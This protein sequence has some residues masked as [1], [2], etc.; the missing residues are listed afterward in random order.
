MNITR[1]TKPSLA[2]PLV[3][4]IILGL[5]GCIGP[6]VDEPLRPPPAPPQ[7]SG[8]LDVAAR[9][10]A[11]YAST[12]ENCSNGGAALECSGVLIRRSS[13]SN[14]WVHSAAAAKLGSVTFSYLRA[15]ATVRGRMP[16]ASSSW[17]SRLP[18]SKASHGLSR[19]VS[20][21]SSRVLRMPEGRQM[22]AVLQ[23]AR[24]LIKVPVLGWPSQ[25]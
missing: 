19:V 16:V 22:A 11:R 18:S 1:S 23:R 15:D 17:T 9:L 3:M 20:I 4:F 13:S 24:P 25:L 12:V 8:V 6:R 2:L 7:P 5:S 21:R 10:N 14:F